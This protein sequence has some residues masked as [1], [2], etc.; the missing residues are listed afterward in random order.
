[1]SGGDVKP[2]D[3]EVCKE[4]KYVRAYFAPVEMQGRGGLHAH[5]HV[6]TYHQVSPFPKK[7]VGIAGIIHDHSSS[8]KF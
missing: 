8:D 2:S 1:M 6:W 7:C 3:S 4:G 5:M